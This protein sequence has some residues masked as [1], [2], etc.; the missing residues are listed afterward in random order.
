[1]V[2]YRTYEHLTEYALPFVYKF[3]ASFFRFDRYSCVSRVYVKPKECRLK[4][5]IAS[6]FRSTRA[7]Q[8]PR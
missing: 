3:H 8:K 6:L 7:S 1:M 2:Q 5:E 4:M